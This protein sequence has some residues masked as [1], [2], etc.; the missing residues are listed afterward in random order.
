MFETTKALCE[1]F[2]EMGVPGF[3][4]ILMR[5]GKEIFRHMGGFSDLEKKIPIRGDELYN[6][7]SCS[8][9]ATITCAM[10]LWEQGK[11]DL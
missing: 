1:R 6:I 3:D 5:D 8:K 2:L 11:F 7:Y 10:Q 4:L 9:P